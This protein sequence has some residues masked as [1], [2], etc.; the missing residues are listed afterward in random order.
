M[1]RSLGC[2]R[3]IAVALV[4]L[5][6]SALLVP[7]AAA[8]IFYPPPVPPPPLVTTLIY[9]RSCGGPNVKAATVTVERSTTTGSASAAS[10]STTPVATVPDAGGLAFAPDGSLLV[11]GR[12]PQVHRVQPAAGTTEGVITTPDAV[13]GLAVTPDGA[14]IYG[15]GPGALSA[16]SIPVPGQPSS[17][18]AAV[19]LLGSDT[20]ID[21][22]AFGPGFAVDGRAYYRTANAVSGGIVGVL[23]FVTPTLAVTSR[24]LT[25]LPSSHTLL[26]DPHSAGLVLVGPQHVTSVVLGPSDTWAATTRAMPGPPLVTGTVDGRGHAYLVNSGGVVV[27]VDYVDADIAAASS[28]IVTSGIFDTCVS[29][30][31]PLYGP[32]TVPPDVS[33]T[34][35]PLAEPPVRGRNHWQGFEVRNQSVHDGADDVTFA[36]VLPA[37]MTVAYTPSPQGA[38]FVAGP[39]V[40]CQLGTI[41]AG[42]AV[43]VG[44]SVIPEIAGP[45]TMLAVVR[46]SASDPV[47]AN[48]TASREVGVVPSVTVSVTNAASPDPALLGD[49]ATYTVVVTNDGAVPATGVVVRDYL[50]SFMHF[51]T[52]SSA[53][54]SC[55]VG[56]SS[57]QLATCEFGTLAPGAS[58]TM[59]ASA[60]LPSGVR[61]S[62][63]PNN[64]YVDTNEPNL[65]SARTSVSQEVF[66]A[67]A[68]AVGAA[69][70]APAGVVVVATPR[71]VATR[72]TP[73][74]FRAWQTPVEV[75]EFMTATDLVVTARWGPGLRADASASVASAALLVGSVLA[76]GIAASC[77]ASTTAFTGATTIGRLRLGGE[78]LPAGSP[79]PN[80]IVGDP[81]TASLVLNEQVT[82]ART[83]TVRALHLRIGASV[84]I[85]VGEVTCGLRPTP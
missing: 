65:G 42:G 77:S 28:S 38:C 10:V 36:L 52:V 29:A 69:V 67:D 24:R 80:T 54:G 63:I 62:S 39:L 71:V 82:T 22:V 70:S 17:S 31:A 79:A 55:R 23:Q 7:P 34:I 53:Q 49:E 2:R 60:L 76:E 41:P 15:T 14:G 4:V 1:M 58:A 85:V 68:G 12:G 64:A 21:A 46:S 26:F 48:N 33:V 16:M 19:T 50:P 11:A 84:D 66:V 37:G 45:A 83:I 27:V 30:V 13:F 47:P 59:T 18:G 3:A 74:P 40:G 51:T 6:G 73:E 81:S 56:P 72:V 43:M 20:R 9:S 44:M 25:N 35:S 32:G 8:V 57:F 78:D 75:G 61:D 5:G